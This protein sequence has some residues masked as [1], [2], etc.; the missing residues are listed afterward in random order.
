MWRGVM[1]D[2]AALNCKLQKYAAQLKQA[3]QS[4]KKRAKGNWRRDEIFY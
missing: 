2:H 3:L 4:R 1:V